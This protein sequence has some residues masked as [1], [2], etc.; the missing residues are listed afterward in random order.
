MSKELWGSVSGTAYRG[1]NDE[2]KNA[3]VVMYLSGSW[4]IGQ[5]DKTIGNAFDWVAVP[6]PVRPGQLHR[7]AGRR[8]RSSPSRRR[9]I[10]R[11]S[12][13]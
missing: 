8:R 12:P 7:H 10:P 4:Q 6:D 1:A 5:F 2:F 11:K 3:Q 9:S 13:A